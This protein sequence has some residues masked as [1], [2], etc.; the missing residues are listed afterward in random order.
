MI[1]AQ[2]LCTEIYDFI[3][4][5]PATAPHVKRLLRVALATD[6]EYFRFVTDYRSRITLNT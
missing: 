4:L 3:G 2:D 6:R 5:C 1:V